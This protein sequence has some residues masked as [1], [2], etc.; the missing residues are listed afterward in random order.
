MFSGLVFLDLS[1]VYDRRVLSLLLETSSSLGPAAVPPLVLCLLTDQLS[2]ASSPRCPPSEFLRAGSRALPTPTPRHP[3]APRRCPRH[4]QVC[5]HPHIP[6]LHL[7]FGP[8][9]S[10]SSPY[11]TCALGATRLNAAYPW[12]SLRGPWPI[13]PQHFLPHVI[14]RLRK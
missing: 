13:C 9:P 14:P 12:Q 8:H 7:Q 10:H 3:R 11:W 1:G 6:H 4:P 2:S 5:L